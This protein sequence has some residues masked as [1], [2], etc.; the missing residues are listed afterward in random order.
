MNPQ[1]S[2]IFA[3]WFSSM[4]AKIQIFFVTKSVVV[5]KS[6]MWYVFIYVFE[7]TEH[8]FDVE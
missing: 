6:V 4:T 3:I 7:I 1:N 2:I 8:D 5:T